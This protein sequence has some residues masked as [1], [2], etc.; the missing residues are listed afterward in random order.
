MSDN[1]EKVYK[2][3]G[4]EPCANGV[5]FGV[6]EWVK[7]IQLKWFGHIERK[8][9]E[10]FV[11]KVYV[12]E[13]DG[14]SGK[15]R[16]LVRWNTETVPQREAQ[17]EEHAEVT[18]EVPSV[19]AKVPSITAEMSPVTAEVLTIT[20]EARDSSSIEMKFETPNQGTN[21]IENQRTSAPP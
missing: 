2:R 18:A 9:N 12:S 7:R 11:K 1:Y 19:T 16:P 4:M 20:A 6:V 5:K 14:P 21:Q 10:E 13:I 15:G 8:N 3:C 17:Q